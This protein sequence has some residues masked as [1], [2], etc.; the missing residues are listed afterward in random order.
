MLQVS[1]ISLR[2]LGISLLERGSIIKMV[3]Y[4]LEVSG[5]SLE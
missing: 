2:V 5:I 4:P 3:G 1:E